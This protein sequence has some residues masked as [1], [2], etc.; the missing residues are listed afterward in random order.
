MLCVFHSSKKA[1]FAFAAALALIV[2]G[3]AT[4]A[5]AQKR[6]ERGGRGGGEG[7]GGRGG[8]GGGEATAIEGAGVVKGKVTLTGTP[9]AETQL[10]QVM[11]GTP[12]C[13]DAHSEPLF[14][15]RVVANAA[16]ELKDVFVWVKS[17]LPADFKAPRN[18]SEVMLDQIGCMYHP[19]VFAFQTGQ[20]FI[21]K[22]SDSTLHNVHAIGDDGKGKDYFNLAMPTKDMTLDK[23]GDFR[24][25]DIVVKFKCEVHPWMF[26]YAG[27]CDH[28]YFAVTSETGDFAIPNLPPGK[29]V[30]GAW[31]RRA[32]FKEMTV[33]VPADGEATAN[34]VYEFAAAEAPA[35]AP[36]P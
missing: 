24:S 36:A 1:R 20:K 3:L 33:E 12:A 25:Q 11:A 5:S 30:V 9:P 2:L 29:Y 18:T 28:P 6:P 4:D 35:A 19:S 16:G 21:I 8:R 10:N 17:G 22:N 23:T 31:Q 13:A 15:D 7:R 27:V 26:A 32:G 14:T 34:F